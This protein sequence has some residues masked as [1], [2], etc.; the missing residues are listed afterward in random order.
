MHQTQ[1]LQKLTSL[2]P[3]PNQQKK[4]SRGFLFKGKRLSTFKLY[5]L[6]TLWNSPNSPLSLPSFPC[7]ILYQWGH[8]NY[9][10]VFF[11]V[12][13]VVVVVFF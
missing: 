5:E 4:F 1:G 7:G 13:F 3:R 2:L 6:M 10:L 12:F 11:F 9:Q 8:F